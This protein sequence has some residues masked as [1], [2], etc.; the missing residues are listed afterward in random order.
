[1]RKSISTVKIMLK[2][3]NGNFVVTIMEVNGSQI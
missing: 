1:M 2:L 3:E